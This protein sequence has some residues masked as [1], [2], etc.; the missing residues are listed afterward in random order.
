MPRE[1]EHNVGVANGHHVETAV[2]PEREIQ[3][4]PNDLPR[5]VVLTLPNGET[6]RF[7]LEY[8]RRTKGLFLR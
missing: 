6:K 1:I 7:V 3:V 8:A 2:A 5:T 4:T